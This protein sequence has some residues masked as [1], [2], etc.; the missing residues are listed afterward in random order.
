MAVATLNTQVSFGYQCVNCNKCFK[1]LKWIFLYCV[2]NDN[3]DKST[4]SHLL[5]ALYLSQ[6][7]PV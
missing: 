3:V 2:D 4:W 5:G 1:V 7:S 6:Q